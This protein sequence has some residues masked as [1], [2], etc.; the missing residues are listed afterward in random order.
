MLNNRSG[1]KVAVIVNDMSEI[2][3]DSQ[4]IDR[5]DSPLSRVDEKLVEMSNGCICCTCARF[6]KRLRSMSDLVIYHPSKTGAYLD[7]GT[8]AL[9]KGDRAS[10]E[11]SI[12][13]NWRNA[14]RDEFQNLTKPIPMLNETRRIVTSLHERT[15]R[16]SDAPF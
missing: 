7:R 13:R 16:G 14:S 9:Q 4:L 8:Q 10:A 12:T 6:Q 15:M 3:I 1:L 11:Q 2:N 5:N